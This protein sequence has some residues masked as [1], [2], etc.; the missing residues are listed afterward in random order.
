MG[1]WGMH[2][3]NLRWRMAI[4]SSPQ[5]GWFRK[6]SVLHPFPKYISAWGVR[7]LDALLGLRPWTP[8]VD[9][10]LPEYLSF[11][12]NPS[13]QSYRADDATAV[14]VKCS[15]VCFVQ[16]RI[17]GCV[18]WVQNI[19]RYKLSYTVCN[20]LNIKSNQILYYC[21][22]KSWPESWPTLPATHWNN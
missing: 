12:V 21:V 1:R 9:F 3:P 7:P 16:L 4:L 14:D 19:V 5:Y 20:K 8:L 17:F 2:P 6:I 10:H 18:Q 22:P 13:P 11:C 15:S